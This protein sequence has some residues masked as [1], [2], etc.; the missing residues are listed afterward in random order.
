MLLTFIILRKKN[1]L[2]D[3]VME[4]YN[5]NTGITFLQDKNIIKMSEM[6]EIGLLISFTV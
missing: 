5:N 1:N 6:N 2:N 3:L 4:V